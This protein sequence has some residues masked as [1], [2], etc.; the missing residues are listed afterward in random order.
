MR[1]AQEEEVVNPD[2]FILSVSFYCVI[3][4]DRLLQSVGPSK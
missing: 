4:C 3:V 2:S 1:K